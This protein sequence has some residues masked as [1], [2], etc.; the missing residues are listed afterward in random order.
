MSFTNTKYDT[1]SSSQTQAS[2][3]SIFQYMT[4]I[5]AHKHEKRCFEVQPPFLAYVPSGV[6][7]SNINI[8]NDL[9]G[10]TKSLNKC[11]N[12]QH[13]PQASQ[14]LDVDPHNLNICSYTKN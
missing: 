2:N 7:W 5:T 3:K 1:C 13:K 12:C 6:P 14:Q 8:E 9:R 4:D 10:I 11:I